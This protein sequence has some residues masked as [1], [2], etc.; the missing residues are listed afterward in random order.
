MGPA[1][2]NHFLEIHL[3]KKPNQPILDIL[4]AFA[5]RHPQTVI[6]IVYAVKSGEKKSYSIVPSE[7]TKYEDYGTLSDTFA[8]LPY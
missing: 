1:G 6:R 5:D 8:A 3:P 2:R 4:K 7:I